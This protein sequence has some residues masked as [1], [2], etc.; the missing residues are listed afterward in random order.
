MSYQ[1]SEDPAVRKY[2][3]RGGYKR[4]YTGVP[5]GAYQMQDNQPLQILHDSGFA[6]GVA[7]RVFGNPKDPEAAYAKYAKYE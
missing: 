1:N 6:A 4:G 5:R 2:A 3:F 7:D